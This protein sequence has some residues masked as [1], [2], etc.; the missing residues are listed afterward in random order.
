MIKTKFINAVI[1]L[2]SACTEFHS[3]LKIRLN[4]RSFKLDWNQFLLEKKKREVL[5]QF[6]II[7]INYLEGY[8]RERKY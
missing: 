3:V 4:T 1:I 6:T 2:T 8:A 7:L 5:N